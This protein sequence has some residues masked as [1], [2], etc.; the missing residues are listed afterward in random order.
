[1]SYMALA[2]AQKKLQDGMYLEAA[3]ESRKA[4]EISR[5]MPPEEAFDH[6]GFD[7]LCHA[8]LAAA[9]AGLGEYEACLRSAERALRY[10]NRRGEL[11]QDE[12]KQWIATVFSRGVALHETGSSVEAEKVLRMAG[13]MIAERKGDLP[14]KEH[15]SG[16]IEKRLAALREAGQPLHKPGYRAWWEFWS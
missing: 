2:E 3:A 16:D 14:G 12:G 13:E 9:E 10:F 6:D 4:M 8:A 1:M 15:M 5:T 7:G 11:Q